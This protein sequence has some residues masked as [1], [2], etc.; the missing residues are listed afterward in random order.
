MINRKEE[1]TPPP[2]DPQSPGLSTPH[3]HTHPTTITSKHHHTHTHANTK[4]GEIR[5]LMGVWTVLTIPTRIPRDP[6][7][8]PPL[9]EMPAY[10]WTVL[11]LTL[12]QVCV[13]DVDDECCWGWW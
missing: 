1:A 10:A 8:I 4:Q 6:R 11:S 3:T 12:A 7:D 9:P 13:V 5:Q 2:T